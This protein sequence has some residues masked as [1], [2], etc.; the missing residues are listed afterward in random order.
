MNAVELE[1]LVTPDGRRWVPDEWA[2]AA[3]SDAYSEGIEQGREEAHLD[4][5]EDGWNSGHKCG[6][7][8]GY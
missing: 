2:A 6:L 7:T 1:I 3:W 5:F 8:H 4:G